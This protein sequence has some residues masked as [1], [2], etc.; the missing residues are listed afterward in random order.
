[1]TALITVI[2]IIV[3]LAA[4]AGAFFVLGRRDTSKAIGTLSA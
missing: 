3:V 1:M 2:V 4:I